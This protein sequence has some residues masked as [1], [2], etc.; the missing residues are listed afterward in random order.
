MKTCRF[1]LFWY[2]R[3]TQTKTLLQIYYSEQQQERE[4]MYIIII[5]YDRNVIYLSSDLL[6]T[7]N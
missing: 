4:C 2:L 7:E 6:Q 3:I 5:I 1:S